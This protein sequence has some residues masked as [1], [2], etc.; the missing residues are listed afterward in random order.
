V[1]VTFD[2]LGGYKHPDHI[3]VH[4][5][6]MQAYH[7]AANVQFEDGM[8]PYRAEK[9]YYHVFPKDMLRV[10]VRVLPLL[11]MNPRSFGR[12]HD[13]DL[14]EIAQEGNFPTHARIDISSVRYRKDEATACHA[15]QLDGF[16]PRRGPLNWL[17]R[18]F[19]NREYFMRAYPP[20]EPNLRE[21]H[22]FAG[23]IPLSDLN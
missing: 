13:I 4:E 22:L 16:Q 12:N 14:V 1:V 15:S 21:S 5:A 9:L 8:P 2:P 20:A 6:T 19:G 10:A 23:T 3:K 17:M 7:Q 18:R 11:G